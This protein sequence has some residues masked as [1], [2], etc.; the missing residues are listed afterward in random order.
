MVEA[1]EVVAVLQQR[2]PVRAGIKLVFVVLSVRRSAVELLVWPA[3]PQCLQI[4]GCILGGGP[5]L[6]DGYGMTYGG[7]H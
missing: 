5:P 2:L 4:V 6:F 7:L 3:V 1:R